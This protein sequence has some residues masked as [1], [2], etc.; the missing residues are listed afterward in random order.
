MV[1]KIEYPMVDRDNEIQPQAQAVE[2]ALV[3][4][5]MLN[6]VREDPSQMR[7]MVYELARAKLKIDMAR[8]IDITRAGDAERKRL[9]SALETAIQGVE[10][11]TSRQESLE[12]PE[13]AAPPPQI[14]SS[15][16]ATLPSM[17]LVPVQR[18][19]QGPS[20]SVMPMH[21]PDPVPVHEAYVPPRNGFA[22]SVYSGDE[23]P[24]PALD[25]RARILLSPLSQGLIALALVALVTGGVV[26]RHR[27]S[28]MF[29]SRPIN[30]VVNAPPQPTAAEAKAAALAALPFPVPKDYGIYAVSHG[31]LSEL[32]LL[33]LQVPDKRIAMSS[34]LSDPSR[35]IIPD[36][37]AKFILYRRDLAAAAPDRLDVRVIARVT[38]ALK[39]DANGKPMFTPV[40]DAWN[41]RNLSY[42]F[43]V[44]PIAE[45]PEMLLVQSDNPDFVLPAG[46]Y[47]LDLKGQGYDFAVAGNIT[48]PWQCL[49]RTDAAN[50]VFYSDCE[51]QNPNQKK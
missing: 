41:I 47:V 31:A 26:Y 42:E 40:T 39:F 28:E 25:R 24:P 35:T 20:T 48:D 12:G 32:H 44:R 38:R 18:P 15:R 37:K 43:R 10:S 13:G 17:S 11:F 9:A 49:E 33:G 19:K 36:G 29:A 3:L 22:R 51:I 23:M 27:I 45:N 4:S 8:S 7:S 34:P 16:P 14:G 6:V 1:E 50:G 46:R 21:Q 5:Q 2:Y 30:V